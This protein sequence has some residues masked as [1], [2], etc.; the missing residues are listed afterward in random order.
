MDLLFPGRK[1]KEV[2]EE[3]GDDDLDTGDKKDDGDVKGM[4]DC[5]AFSFY[6]FLHTILEY[7]NYFSW[8]FIVSQICLS[9]A[10]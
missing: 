6:K 5:S 8:S 10:S 2:L 7:L 9:V 4:F 1:P 3:G